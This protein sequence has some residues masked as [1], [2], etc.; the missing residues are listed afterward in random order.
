M[1]IA[2]EGGG[3]NIVEGHQVRSISIA[4]GLCDDTAICV[5]IDRQQ[6]IWAGT[7]QG[8]NLI[9][10]N[11]VSVFNSDSGLVHPYVRCLLED[12]NGALW[13]GTKNGD[14]CLG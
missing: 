8:L 6:R 11:K 14:Q 9:D 7:R 5:V 4:E 2:T 3:V 10:G 12:R 13:I 1:V